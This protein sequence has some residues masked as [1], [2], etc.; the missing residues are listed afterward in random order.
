MK[1]RYLATSCG[2][3]FLTSPN[4]HIRMNTQRV[5]HVI[6]SCEAQIRS[7]TESVFLSCFNLALR[8]KQELPKASFYD[9]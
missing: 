5:S 9:M 6:K 1:I 8:H 3:I 4:L 7:T 2:D